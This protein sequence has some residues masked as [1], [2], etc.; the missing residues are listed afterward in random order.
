M[1]VSPFSLPSGISIVT[2][3]DSGDFAG[4]GAYT[5]ADGDQFRVDCNCSGTLAPSPVPTTLVVIPNQSGD[6]SASPTPAPTKESLCGATD[7]FSITS[8]QLQALEG[9]YSDTG[10]ILSTFFTQTGELTV[11][12]VAVYMGYV[13]FE[14]A[15]VSERG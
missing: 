4:I 2:I 7:S 3:L 15:D 12:E 10:S 13:D 9:C 11:G 14:D 5:Q 1:L 6:E 8:E